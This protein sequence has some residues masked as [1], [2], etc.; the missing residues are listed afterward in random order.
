MNPR[1]RHVIILC[2]D[3]LRFDCLS[4]A[5]DRSLLRPYGLDGLVSTPTL[6]RLASEGVLFTQAVST[7]TYTTTAHASLFTGLYPPRHG[8]RAF[9]ETPL[10]PWVTT[11][12]ERLHNQ[13]FATWRS[14][15]FCY[16]H[17]FDLDRG[18]ERAFDGNDEKLFAALDREKPERLHLFAH[19][20]DVHE[21]YGFSLRS[22]PQDLAESMEMLAALE[23][24]LG[25][26]GSGDAPAP[27]PAD[28]A[29]TP[30]AGGP[31]SDALRAIMAGAD[32]PRTAVMARFAA[33]QQTLQSTPEGRREL[34]EMYVRG[35]NL[36]D[37]RRLTRFIDALKRRGILD[38]ALLIVLADHGET[39]YGTSFGHS[40]PLE[41]GAI[42]IPLILRAPG[43]LP[44]GRT[45]DR[46]AGIVDI[47]PTILEMLGLPM[48]DDPSFEAPQGRSLLGSLDRG[49]T[50]ANDD[51]VAY[52]E[53]WSQGEGWL[54]NLSHFEEC[55][56][57]G[58]LT[59]VPGA[60]QLHERYLRLPP[61]K[62]VIVGEETADGAAPAGGADPPT[63]EE[64]V[65]AAYLRHLG[66]KPDDAGL[67]HHAGLLANGLSR[68]DLD[69]A[70][71]SS[72]EAALRVR[73]YDLRAPGGTQVTAPNPEQLAARA[74]LLAALPAIR[75]DAGALAAGGG[76]ARAGDPASG[77]LRPVSPEEMANLRQHLQG[78]GYIAIESSKTR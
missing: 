46:Q 17:L 12:A 71:A 75:G 74:R 48:V 29:A 66:R 32:S 42:R 65:T 28:G 51:R 41:E 59:P 54:S 1:P 40:G 20:F 25:L 15:E 56:R 3:A 76:A 14:D 21:P 31:A 44:R 78:L 9:F 16:F 57:T 73:L 70:L 24:R 23:A 37:R 53:I 69:A 26:S 36:F 68:A 34:F 60:A 7:A 64:F 4:A 61:W 19:F 10:S 22:E 43:L 63:D 52:G 49:V 50:A 77:G 18:M 8:V 5:P 2:I 67:A 30:V 6:D 33:V 58:V 35:V 72:E 39:D 62:A 27:A 45:V 13:G 55:R 11:L 47:T 38:D